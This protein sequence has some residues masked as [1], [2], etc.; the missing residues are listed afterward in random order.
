MKLSVVKKYLRIGYMID[1]S[2]IAAVLIRAVA[3]GVIV[4][5]AISTIPNI[6][7]NQRNKIVITVVVVVMYALLDYFSSALNMLRGL[8][9]RTVCTETDTNATEELDEAIRRVEEEVD[10]ILIQPKGDIV[11]SQEETEALKPAEP[12]EPFSML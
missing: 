9:C 1:F 4:Y 11:T 5:Y 2:L 6:P 8:M 7:I 10:N 3:L 12:M